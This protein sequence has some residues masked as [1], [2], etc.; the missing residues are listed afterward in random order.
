[1]TGFLDDL[2][3]DEDDARAALRRTL[4][5]VEVSLEKRAQLEHALR[6]RIVIE[7]AKGVLA[8]RLRLSLDE[9]FEVLRRAARSNGL[10]IHLVAGRVLDEPETPAVVV[11][12][13][14][15]HLSR[16]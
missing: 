10:K 1:V 13:L 6:S 16:R 9:A 3:E 4:A 5:V 11:A 12:A 15:A 8:E 14:H 2:L 7:Q